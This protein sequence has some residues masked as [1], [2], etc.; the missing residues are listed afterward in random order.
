MTIINAKKVAPRH[1]S[2][3]VSD[4]ID[5]AARPTRRILSVEE[6]LDF[7]AR[8]EACEPGTKWG[9]REV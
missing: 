5:P 8:Y 6:K 4:N 1:Q 9:L 3:D 7:L 2:D